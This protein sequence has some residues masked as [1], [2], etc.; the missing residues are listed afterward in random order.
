MEMALEKHDLS[1][2]TV[3]EFLGKQVELS[4]ID[5]SWSRS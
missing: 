3:V 1:A 5:A 2:N 4:V